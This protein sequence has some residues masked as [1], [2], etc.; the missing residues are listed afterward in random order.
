MVYLCYGILKGTLKNL[1]NL[2]KGC[3]HSA[4][5]QKGHRTAK[6]NSQNWTNIY[7]LPFKVME[8]VASY[9]FFIHMNVKEFKQKIHLVKF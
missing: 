7:V 1:Q 4:M 3:N 8:I 2:S 6:K 5:S 9:Y